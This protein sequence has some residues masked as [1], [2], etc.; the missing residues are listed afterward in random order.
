M[1]KH[2]RRKEGVKRTYL[3]EAFQRRAYQLRKSTNQVAE[4]AGVTR[5]MAQQYFLV[6]KTITYGMWRVAKC[7]QIEPA[8]VMALLEAS[9]ERDL[10]ESKGAVYE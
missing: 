8:H 10:L 9:N 4:E 7:L 3:G 6:P 2:L 1:T 5:R